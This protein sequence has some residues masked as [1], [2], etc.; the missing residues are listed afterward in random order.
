MPPAPP[1]LLQLAGQPI[2]V[3]LQPGAIR[4]Q[5]GVAISER[6]QFLEHICDVARHADLIGLGMGGAEQVHL[7]ALRGAS[8]ELALQRFDC[9]LER[10]P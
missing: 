8:I 6:P 10:L 3:R 5:R 7:R 1:R 9:S 4:V 2:H